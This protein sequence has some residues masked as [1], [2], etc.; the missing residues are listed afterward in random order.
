M[1]GKEKQGKVN[2]KVDQGK[3]HKISVLVGNGFDIQILKHLK[4]PV[5]TSYISFKINITLV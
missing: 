5:D 3:I 1:R 4:E 2:G